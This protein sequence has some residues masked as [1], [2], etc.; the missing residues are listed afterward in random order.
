MP[1]AEVTLCVILRVPATGLEAFRAYENAVLPLLSDHGG[2]LRQ[3]LRT[4][5]GL[6]EVHV[7]WFPST[8]E[9]AAYRADPR[10]AFRAGLLEAS[11]ATAEV[12]VVRDVGEES[13]PQVDHQD[14]AVR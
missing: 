6:A 4:E 13:V 7:I 8:S 3:R 11:G 12:L 10:R 5:D 14:A 9:F 2:I 1:D